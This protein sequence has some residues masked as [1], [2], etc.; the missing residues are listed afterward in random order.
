MR[1]GIGLGL[2]VA[3]ATVAV[4]GEGPVRERIRER[5]AGRKETPA[6]T[7]TNGTTVEKIRVGEVSRTYRLHVPASHS[8]AAYAVV[9]SFHGLNSNAVQEETLT[10]FSTLA[11][12]EGFIVVY[13]EGVDAKWRFLGRDDSD[14][15]Y[16]DA[17]IADLKRRFPIN[18]RQIYANGISNGAQMVWRLA[19]VRPGLLAAVG[20]VSGGYPWIGPESRPSAILFHGTKDRLLPY[21]GRGLLMPVRDFALGWA[22]KGDCKPE[23]QGQVVYQKGD[24]T[25]EQWVCGRRAVV[26]YT[27]AGKGHSWPGSAM[28][29]AITSSDINAT[30]AMWTFFQQ[31]SARQAEQGDNRPSAADRNPQTTPGPK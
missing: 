9:L 29:A 23:P 31:C 10:G 25:G 28:P 27:L 18:G 2:L 19:C 4:A 7:A 12:K 6:Q 14:V 13:P 21:N 1:D 24:A 8:D 30:T 26:L 15:L 20:F 22:A 11:D 16:V 5:I 3:I 17:V